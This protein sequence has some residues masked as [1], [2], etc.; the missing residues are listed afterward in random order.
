MGLNPTL[1][2]LTCRMA[3]SAPWQCPTCKVEVATPYCAACGERRLQPGDLKLSGLLAQIA[4]S[5]S[6]VDGRLL[7][8][9]RSLLVAP[10]ELTL[11]YL[12]GRRKPFIAPFPF[13]LIVNVA[14]FAVQSFSGNA[15]FSTALASHLQ[16]QDWSALARALVDR[17]LQ[18]LGTT[19]AA[20][21]PLFDQAV[22]VNAK[23]L[24]ILMTLP[25]AAL[26]AVLL[27]GGGRPLVMH[28]VFSLLFYAF[29]MAWLCVL[30]GVLFLL[31]ALAGLDLRSHAVDW[32][33]FAS[34]L[35]ATAVYL[36]LAVG[37]A[38]AEEGLPRAL[39]VALLTL[40]VGAGI[41][42]YR[43]TVFLITLYWS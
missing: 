10:G 15:I 33:L 36:Y 18:D 28:L 38:Y 3:A 7:R 39:K 21:T 34:L 26:L 6:S 4:Q 23:S 42:G 5:M 29:L 37:R 12:Q 27:R 24:V 1:Q 32:G 30:L 35:G 14:F 9:L 25:F 31:T 22:Q 19:L 13:F 16:V 43:F 20:Y 11:A 17:R 40:A 8:T 2:S 41:L